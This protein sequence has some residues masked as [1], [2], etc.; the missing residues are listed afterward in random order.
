LKRVIY[1]VT[2]VS[3]SFL[4][5]SKISLLLYFDI[6]KLAGSNI[7]LLLPPS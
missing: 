7:F 1:L 2:L 4:Y 5:F 6:D 3:S